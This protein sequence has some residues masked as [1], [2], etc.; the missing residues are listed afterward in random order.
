MLR[1]HFKAVAGAIGVAAVLAVGAAFAAT[2]DGGLRLAGTTYLVVLGILLVVGF[3]GFLLWGAIE[4]IS[5]AVAAFAESTSADKA[6]SVAGAPPQRRRW[7]G[8][9]VAV[10]VVFGWL[11]LNGTFDRA[12][13]SVG[14]N[15]NQCASNAFGAT[16]CGDDLDRYRREVA[17]PAREA[18]DELEHLGSEAAREERLLEQEEAAIATG[19]VR[20]VGR[21]WVPSCGW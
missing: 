20:C 14:L 1:R 10:T 11:Y 6:E 4:L 18:R 13:Y 16:F 8:I 3:L 15:W 7:A 12:L 19:G 5:T 17:E 2:G 21:A 9:A